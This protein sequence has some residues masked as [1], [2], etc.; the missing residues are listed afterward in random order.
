MKALFAIIAVIQLSSCVEIWCKCKYTSIK[1]IVDKSAKFNGLYLSNAG[2]NCPDKARYVLDYLSDEVNKVKP[3]AEHYKSLVEKIKLKSGDLGIPNEGLITGRT[4]L[5][6][7]LKYYE[8]RHTNKIDNVIRLRNRQEKCKRTGSTI[9]QEMDKLRQNHTENL[10]TISELQKYLNCLK[11][12]NKILQAKLNQNS[13]ALHGSTG[14]VTGTLQDATT[15]IPP[16]N[17]DLMKLSDNSILV[18]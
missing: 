14:V 9:V 11:T 1:D 2:K 13:A 18:Y 6:E 15:C 16:V 7:L 12:Q 17:V 4:R 8:D 3:R 5:M 10:S